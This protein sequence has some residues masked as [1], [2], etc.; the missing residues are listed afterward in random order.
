VVPSPQAALVLC[1]Y[2]LAHRQQALLVMWRLL[3]VLAAV[4][5]AAACRSL[6][7]TWPVRAALAA[8]FPWYQALA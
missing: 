5:Q 3:S 8:K 6:A 2:R 7:E 4:V 1:L